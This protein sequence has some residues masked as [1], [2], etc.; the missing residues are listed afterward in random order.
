MNSPKSSYRRPGYIRRRK[1]KIHQ[2]GAKIALFSGLSVALVVS[3]LELLI[4]DWSWLGTI[5]LT[6]V[7]ASSTYY[8]TV[9][10]AAHRLEYIRNALKQIRKHT[11]EHSDLA[12]ESRGDELN[13]L[14]RQV[15][16][17]GTVVE[18]EFEELN[19]LEHYRRDFIGNV[20]HELKTPIFAIRGFAETLLDGAVEDEEVRYVFVEKIVRNADR[21]ANL[22]QDLSEISRLETG[23]KAMNF[24]PF[25]VARWIA[26]VI[27]SVDSMA[28]TS[29]ITL[30]TTLSEDLPSALGDP[31]QLRQ[32]LTNLVINAI[33]YSNPNH[34]VKIKASLTKK[35]TILISVQD[36]GIGISKKHINRLTE[37]FF[38]VDKSRSRLGGGSGLGL[39]IAKHVLAAHDQVLQIKSTPG[40]GSTFR[41]ELQTEAPSVNLGIPIPALVKE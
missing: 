19:N 33:K 6:L 40:K 17:T 31:L 24:Q 41:F 21:L 30:E 25:N 1:A 26:D 2:L 8:A 5:V 13:D 38:R 29:D 22:A 10:Y 28:S 3:I 37:R 7:A 18:R 12:A 36:R 9:K 34:N 23:Q 4:W 15:S 35:N 27:D 32:V 20:S 39:A 16:R 14:I 11:F